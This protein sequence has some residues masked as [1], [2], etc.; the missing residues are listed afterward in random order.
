MVV[1]SWSVALNKMN[2]SPYEI[3]VWVNLEGEGECDYKGWELET[4]LEFLT[5]ESSVICTLVW[6]LEIGICCCFVL[7]TIDRSVGPSGLHQRISETR[8]A[9]TFAFLSSRSE[10]NLH[11]VSGNSIY[12]ITRIG[13]RRLGNL[14]SE[15]F[16]GFSGIPLFFR[17][18]DTLTCIYLIFVK[19]EY[20]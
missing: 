15:I 11:W 17:V 19:D 7:C 5:K 13:F 10:G 18:Y 12:W 3:E 2:V 14:F 8:E 1:H 6:C 16:F 20:K 9:L 4:Q